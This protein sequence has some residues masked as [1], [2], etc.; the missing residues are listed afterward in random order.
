M[1]QTT[2]MYYTHACYM[3]RKDACMLTVYW[4]IDHTAVLQTSWEESSIYKAGQRVT[5]S[6]SL[7]SS[8]LARTSVAAALFSN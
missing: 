1:R 3:R 2:C 7:A 8:V 5:G 6:S 4:S